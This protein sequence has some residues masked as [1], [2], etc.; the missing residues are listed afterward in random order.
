MH[1]K[2]SLFMVESSWNHPSSLSPGKNCLHENDPWCQK[3][4]NCWSSAF[5]LTDDY[6]PVTVL[7]SSESQ[8][9]T[10]LSPRGHLVI[11]GDILIVVLWGWTWRCCWSLVSRAQGCCLTVNI[12]QCNPHNRNSSGP[13]YLWSWGWETLVYI[14]PEK[15]CE[16]QTVSCHGHARYLCLT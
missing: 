16:Q 1:N 4:W 7:H 10:I 14:N 9:G 13:K 15:I 6:F 5:C 3:N 2:C 11:T 8:L 12:A